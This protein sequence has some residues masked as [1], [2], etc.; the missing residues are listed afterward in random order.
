VELLD[1]A[2]KLPVN[3]VSKAVFEVL[4]A[5]KAATGVASFLEYVAK[6]LDKRPR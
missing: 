1:T 2:S 6:K 3:S 5:V 4:D